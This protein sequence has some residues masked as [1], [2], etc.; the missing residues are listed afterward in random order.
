VATNYPGG[1][2]DFSVTT[3]PEDTPLSQAGPGATRNHPQLHEDEGDA[4]E[5][6]QHNAALKGHD[7]S[8]DDTDIHKGAKLKQVYTHEEIDTDSSHTAVHH[9]LGEAEN[10]AAKG[11]HVHDYNDGSRLLNRPYVICTSLTRPAEPYKGLQIY[12][13]DTDR[14]RV[15]G[16]FAA[17][18]PVAGL[19]SIDNFDQGAGPLSTI[20]WEPVTYMSGDTTHGTMGTPDG[21]NLSWTDQS[22]WNNNGMTRRINPVDA[23][24]Q[25]DDQ[26]ITWQTGDVLIEDILLFTEGASNDKF[27]RMSDDK[28]SYIRVGVGNDGA[29]V[30]YTTTGRANEK[31][32]GTFPHVNA[33][34]ANIVWR[35]QLVG[36]TLS[37]YRAGEFMGSVVDSQN[38]TNKGPAY[39]GWGIGMHAGTRGFGQTTPAN[40]QWVRIQDFVYYIATNRWTILPVGK[41]PVVR[42]R[43][44]A[45][46]KLVSAG[47]LVEWSDELEDDF[48]FFNTA[49]KT[50]VVMKEPGLYDIKVAI[51]WNPSVTPD[52]A[53]V[54][55]CI[56][57]IETTIRK[58]Q[59][60]RGGGFNP[61]FSQTLD[62]SGQLRF[63]TNDVLT[64]KVRYTASGSIIDQIFTWF[65]S[66]SKINSRIDLAYI[67]V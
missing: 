29:N 59:Y 47:S 7:H 23:V 36:R 35:A 66:A 31:V 20:N 19:N 9:T 28:Q 58:Q 39:R 54:V 61:G 34:V 10:Q 3:A 27:F 32:L 16:S 38:V 30:Y 64:V 51:Q 56:N 40:E 25:T 55:L 48:D 46:Q 13:T 53:H 42:L 5:A 21:Q 63:N 1:F 18:E 6:L 26:V 37:L 52:V 60:M 4:I 11:N 65:D 8:G 12:E 15:W 2:D 17:T 49:N 62:V 57:G 24:T 67:R 44:S 50:D 33:D 43:Q 41:I 14:V 22:N 45:N